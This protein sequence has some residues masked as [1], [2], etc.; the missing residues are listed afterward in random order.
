VNRV[1]VPIGAGSLTGN[2]IIRSLQLLVFLSACLFFIALNRAFPFFP[3]PSQVLGAAAELFFTGEIYSHLLV[4]LY[5]TLVGFVIGIVLGIWIGL[6]L[7]LSRI[8]AEIFEPIILAAYAVPKI[9][10]LPVLLMIFGVGLN[11]KIANAALHAVF[12]IILNTL[13]GIREV[14]RV[15]V[16]VA[17]SM[18]ATK[19]QSFRKVYF[20][21][22]VLPIFAGLRI[23][24]GFAFL[25]SLLA[26]LFEAKTGLGFL[27]T[28]FYNTGQIAKMLAVILLVFVLTMSIN[29]GMKR[30]ENGLSRWRAAWNY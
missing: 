29:A 22:M 18:N 11:S 3:P 27:V 23:A 21:S 25:G 26:E 10:F 30:I 2:T 20:P 14:N 24:L 15:F 4:T 19:S 8:L 1:I 6:L 7:G 16:R 13:V 28:R 12:P 5:E 9:I 17:L